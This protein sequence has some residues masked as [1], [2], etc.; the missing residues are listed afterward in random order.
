[1][2]KE[3]RYMIYNNIKK[4][5]QFP[6]ICET[7][8]KGANTCLFNIIGNDVRKDRF[9]VR[10]VEKTK[11]Y[12]IKENLKMESKV[13]ELQYILP[14]ISYDELKILVTRNERSINE[15][16]NNGAKKM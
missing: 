16:E 13:R 4:C 9:E 8:E 15:S 6:S 11:A 3:Y 2:D 1:M 10:K 5:F 14:N 12:E 7:T